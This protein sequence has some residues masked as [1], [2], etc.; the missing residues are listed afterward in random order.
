MKSIMFSM[1]LMLFAV[2]VFAG[3]TVMIDLEQ[4]PGE[5]AKAVLAAKKKV[6][7]DLPTTPEKAKEWAEVG[8]Q[9]GE[10]IAATAKALGEEVNDFVKTPVGM[11]A[12]LLVIWHVVGPDLWGIV[13]GIPAWI[14]MSSIILWSFRYFH[15]SKKIKEK[16]EKGNVSVRYEKMHD[17][18]SNESKAVSGIC[19]V[20]LFIANTITFAIIVF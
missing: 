6:N 7:E 1:L 19:H 20:V 13:G 4:L 15:M 16:D 18:V 11:G 2:P 14:I 9:I 8:E 17:F 5:T 12:A 10:A 3:T